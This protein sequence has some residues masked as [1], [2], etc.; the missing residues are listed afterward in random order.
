MEILI[1][2]SNEQLLEELAEALQ[3][4]YN[5]DDLLPTQVVNTSVADYQKDVIIINIE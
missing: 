1:K 5:I 4:I 2:S 3:D